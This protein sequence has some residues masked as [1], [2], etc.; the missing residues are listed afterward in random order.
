MLVAVIL[1]STCL[2]TISSAQASVS[3]KFSV[4]LKPEHLGYGT[5]V[6]FK[7]DII[8]RTSLVPPALTEVDLRY[9]GDLGIA[10]S[11][12]G[13]ATCSVNTLEITGPR[14]CPA[15]AH[16]GYGTV[17]AEIAVHGEAIQEPATLTVLRAATQEGHISMYFYAE[18]WSPVQDELLLP[19][20]LLPA[21]PPFG[22]RIHIAVPIV[23]AYA[24]GPYVSVAQINGTLG[25]QH[26]TYYHHIGNHYIPYNPQGILLPKHCPH[27]GFPFAA[28]FTFLD[29]T[30]ANANATVPCPRSR[31]RSRRSKIG[32][33]IP[34]PDVLGV[35]PATFNLGTLLERRE[36]KR[37]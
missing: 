3:L 13:L 23:E 25:P 12:I 22:G 33:R 2:A 4:S 24:D 6:G 31:R 34:K 36:L 28:Q 11:G 20:A 29:G 9:P 5:T 35:A 16:M 17:L 37:G 27:H 21:E 30:H 7:F 14:G 15:E 1:T 32:T 19:A 8:P 18:G 10:L 26:L